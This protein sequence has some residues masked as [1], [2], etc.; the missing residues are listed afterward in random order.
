MS[1][2]KIRRKSETVYRVRW[3]EGGRNRARTFS[4]HRDAR[5]FDAEL[6]RHRRAGSLAQLDRGTET[7]DEYVTA[8]WV[9]AHGTALAP[10]TRRSYAYAYDRH[11]SPR[12]GSTPLRELTPDAIARLQADLLAGGL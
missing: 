8:V 9:P 1:V 4:T 6:R 10:N 3:R 12:L 7:L 5:D 2:E 11:I